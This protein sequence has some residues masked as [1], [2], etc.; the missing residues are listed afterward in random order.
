MIESLEVDQYWHP[1]I[2]EGSLDLP[3]H[4][5]RKVL[6]PL[7]TVMP[8][9]Q[10]GCRARESIRGE[11]LKKGGSAADC[12]WN[13][14]GS[15]LATRERERRETMKREYLVAIEARG[16]A[17]NHMVDHSVPVAIPREE[18]CVLVTVRKATSGR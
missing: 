18:A 13:K 17:N 2:S 10:E 6:V 5:V 1:V 7:G 16:S 15:V 9:W 14:A 8:G 12:D 4:P 11:P 3:A